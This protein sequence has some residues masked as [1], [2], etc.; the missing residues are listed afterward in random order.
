MGGNKKGGRNDTKKE[1]KKREKCTYALVNE[2]TG[3]VFE[4][5][6]CQLRGISR[7]EIAY[8]SN[9]KHESHLIVAILHD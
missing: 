8:Q 3:Q 9:L 5:F 2:I 4:G 6:E 7:D 1:I